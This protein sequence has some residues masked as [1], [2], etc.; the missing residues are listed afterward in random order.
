MPIK[1]A[2]VFFT[3]SLKTPYE[4]AALSA[5]N[6]DIKDGSFTCLVGKTGSG[7]STLISML[8]ALLVPTSGEVTIDEFVV[9]NNKKK[10]TKK[11]ANLRKR[12]GVVFQFPE[13]QLF[14]D[15]VEKDVAFGPSNF[16][17][18]KNECLRIAH[19]CLAKVGLDESYYQKS[20]FELSGGEKR[21]VAIAGILALEPK[22]LVLDEP[23]AGLDPKGSNE[24]LSLFK[25]L[26]DEGVTIVFVTHDM[27]IVLEYAS[28]VVVLDDGKI[29]KRCPPFELFLENEE[30]YSLENPLLASVV[31]KLYK[32]GIFLDLKNIKNISTLVAEIVKTRNK[33]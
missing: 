30:Q 10:R 32:N 27:N 11:L 3:Y 9:T 4:F 25:K 24:M 7:K 31:Q 29:V 26:N 8:N 14:E 15:S 19:E 6:L 22:I 13:Y 17:V 18:S 12:V 5:I 21:R 28:D 20:P 16:G 23:T 1:F 33:K 2:D